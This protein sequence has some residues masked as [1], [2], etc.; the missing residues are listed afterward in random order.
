MFTFQALQILIFLIPGFIASAV[1]NALVVRKDK[2]EFGR[3][4]EALVFTL[5]IFT[6]YSLFSDKSPVALST[7]GDNMTYSY[8]SHAFLYLVAISV[9]LPV[10]MSFLVTHDLHMRLSRKLHISK[11]TARTSVW[12]DVFY[13]LDNYVIVNFKD[14]RRIYG[15]PTYF[16]TDPDQ[17]YVFLSNAAW[18]EETEFKPLEGAEGILITPELE[19]ESIEM[20]KD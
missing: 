7:V 11:K 2:N 10:V 15:W 9:I 5:I 17:Q 1:L 14:G 3:I 18:I 12:V 8:D 4:V 16:S 19:I 6:I 13:D 20:L